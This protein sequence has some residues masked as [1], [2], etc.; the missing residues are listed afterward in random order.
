[1]QNISKVSI[2]IPCYS[3]AQYLDEA[4]QSA[5]AQSVPCEIIVVS[6]G[7]IDNSV[8]IAKKYPVIVLEKEN[9]GLA[10][11]RNYGIAHATGE[12]IMSFD[13]DDILKPCAVEEHLKYAEPDTIVTCGL[14]AFGSENYTA[15]PIPATVS[16][17][18]QTNCIYSNSLF[19]KKMWE[20][21]GGFDESE[22]MREGWEDRMFWLEALI[23]G[24]KSVVS[25]RPCLLWRR[26]ANTMSNS[27]NK[28]ADVLQKYIYTKGKKLLD[29]TIS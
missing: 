22:I 29:M 10:S 5:L 12:Y 28:N 11:A 26:H 25:D 18:L 16:I 6:D 9:G 27:A 19:S 1:M 7:A 8:E 3:Y 17:L 13:S 20:D 23:K 21:V 24:Y 15:Y 4:I 2:I 14:I